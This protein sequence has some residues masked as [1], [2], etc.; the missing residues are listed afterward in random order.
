MH[1][2]VPTVGS[3]RCVTIV[4]LKK[5][6][7]GCVN[8]VAYNP[9]SKCL[10]T[11]NTRILHYIGPLRKNNKILENSVSSNIFL[12]LHKLFKVFK[13]LLLIASKD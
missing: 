13:E 6:V 11:M 10:L 12:I 7:M 5:K 2:K 1:H 9:L 3:I 4:Y 8:Q